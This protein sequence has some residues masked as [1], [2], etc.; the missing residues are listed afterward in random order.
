MSTRST[1]TGP[2]PTPHISRHGFLPP[3]PTQTH[4]LHTSDYIN[5]DDED[6]FNSI[7]DRIANQHEEHQANRSSPTSK[8]FIDSL[9]SLKFF[10]ASSSHSCP[11]TCSIFRDDSEFFSE[12]NQLPCNHV[13]HPD[14]IVPWLG[15][16]NSCPLCRYKLPVEQNPKQLK[17][18]VVRLGNVD[19]EGW[20]GVR[21]R[22]AVFMMHC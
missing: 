6:L 17:S 1:T 9:Q 3:N 10:H 20:G 21:I 19:L 11:R 14:C 22:R 15:R 8:S 7:T 18:Y 4:Q 12:V 2:N 13:F 5:S 16:R